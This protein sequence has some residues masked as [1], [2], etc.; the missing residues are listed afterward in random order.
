MGMS[1]NQCAIRPQVVALAFHQ[2]FQA[3]GLDGCIAQVKKKKNRLFFLQIC[4]EKSEFSPVVA[5]QFIPP[6]VPESR[7]QEIRFLGN[8][9]GSIRSVS[10]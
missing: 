6:K 3:T 2:I 8:C 10:V 1:E 5:L 4:L 9:I 7:N